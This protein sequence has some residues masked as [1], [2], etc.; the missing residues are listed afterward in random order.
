MKHII[1]ILLAL[2]TALMLTFSASAANITPDGISVAGNEDGSVTVT[3]SVH[4]PKQAAI[5]GFALYDF[6][7]KSWVQIGDKKISIGKWLN[8]KINARTIK[9]IRFKLPASKVEGLTD[10]DMQNITYC[11]YWSCWCG[12]VYCY[13]RA[14]SG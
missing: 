4:N 14:V 1:S 7:H 10:D 12:D 5:N 3:I 8:V 9:K 2:I 6:S 11:L 13:G